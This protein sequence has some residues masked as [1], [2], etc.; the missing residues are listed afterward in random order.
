MGPLRRARAFLYHAPLLTPHPTF[1]S[2]RDKR[3]RSQ[4]AQGRTHPTGSTV[5]Q[6]EETGPTLSPQEARGPSV[7]PF[8][9]AH[10]RRKGRCLLPPPA[11]RPS[12][13]EASWAEP[14]LPTSCLPSGTGASPHQALPWGH[15]VS[16]C[17]TQCGQSLWDTGLEKRGPCQLRNRIEWRGSRPRAYVCCHPAESWPGPWKASI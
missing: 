2:S 12:W 9:P 4:K 1:T 14:P 10:G 3:L 17:R 15:S 5:A 13:L 16:T 7:D 6:T 11:L 8:S